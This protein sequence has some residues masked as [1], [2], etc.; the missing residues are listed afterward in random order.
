MAKTVLLEVRDRM[1][2]VTMNRTEK[3]KA[4]NNEML[5]TCLKPAPR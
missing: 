2:Y 4:I 3:L 5:G 1:A